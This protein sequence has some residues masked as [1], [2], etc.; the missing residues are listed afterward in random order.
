MTVTHSVMSHNAKHGISLEISAKAV[1]TNNTVVDNDGYGIKVNNTSNVS[2]ANNI[3]SQNDRSINVVQ[4][5]RRPTSA[6][7]AGRDKRQPFPDPTMT[8]LIGPVRV[9]NNVLANQKS[10]DCM[11]CVEDYTQKRSA[12]QIDVTANGDVYARTNASRPTYLVV[13]SRGPGNPAVYT[14]LKSFRAATGQEKS[15]VLLRG[16]W[17]PKPVPKPVPK[18]NPAPSPSPK[19][20][21]S[22]SPTPKPLA[23][24][25]ADAFARTVA[26]GLGN[27]DVGGA[28]DVSGSASSFSVANGA[29][30]IRGEVAKNPR[31]RSRGSGMRTST[32][33]LLS[34]SMTQRAAVG[35][36]SR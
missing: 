17:A 2:I 21:P 31:P 23:A 1:V 4:D 30:R 13:W 32:S 9:S 24:Y 16:P 7:T 10:G 12:K 26:Q 27:A 36:M 6:G 8:W 20:S 5:T 22:P 29:G 3:F 11:L 28:W 33:P 18:P 35:P 19:P 25:A 34:H 14:T 15:G